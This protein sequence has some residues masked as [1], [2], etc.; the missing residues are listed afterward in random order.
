MSFDHL[1]DG[2]EV[3]EGRRSDSPANRFGRSVR[4][5]IVAL[6]ALWTLNCDVRLSN[7]RA[8]AFHHHLEV[9]DHRLHLAHRLRL[10]RKNAPRVVDVDG[11]IGKPVSRLLQD[12][13][14]L[15]QLLEADE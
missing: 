11:T 13:R 10:R 2:C 8:R 7:W 12:S 4:Y 6:L 14:R 3:D 9:V 1:G 5:H 15:T